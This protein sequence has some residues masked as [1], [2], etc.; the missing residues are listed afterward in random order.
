MAMTDKKLSK[1]IDSFFSREL[2]VLASRMKAEG[3]S[4]FPT[5][6]DPSAPSYYINR[7]KRTMDPDDFES[8]GCG[9]L[10]TLERELT[11]LWK[12]RGCEELLTLVPSLAALARS[13][14]D[15]GE[16]DEEVSP[17]IYVMY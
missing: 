12:S 9:S 16:Q 8:A 11:E 15:V 13:L 14:Y 10:D 2:V 5:K 7:K 1:A 17:F 4:F 3:K 6:G